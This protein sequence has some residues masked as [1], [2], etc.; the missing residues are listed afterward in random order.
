MERKINYIISYECEVNWILNKNTDF[1]GEQ[2][3]DEIIKNMKNKYGKFYITM[4]HKEF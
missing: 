4:I 2:R 1:W 3:L